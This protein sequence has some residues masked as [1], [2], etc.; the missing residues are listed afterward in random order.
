MNPGAFVQEFGMGQVVTDVVVP[1]RMVG[2]VGC[3]SLQVVTVLCPSDGSVEGRAAVAAT[4]ADGH[5][6]KGAEG[7]EHLAAE[8]PD[9][10]DEFPGDGVV[11]AEEFGRVGTL[12]FLEREVWG[13]C[14]IFHEMNRM[15]ERMMVMEKMSAY[16]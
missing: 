6:G 7:F 16:R 2:D 10:R 13:Q 12:K 11:N 5:S 14:L 4:D 15:M 9:A 1:F 8:P 3:P